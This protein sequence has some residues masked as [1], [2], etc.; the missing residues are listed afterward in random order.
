MRRKIVVVLI[1]FASVKV[2]FSQSGVVDFIK[3]GK[4]DAN[5][6]M[7]KYLDPFALSL[8]D[9][10][11]NAW[12]Y[13]AETHK[14]LGF[15]LSIST[16]AVMIPSSAKTFDLRSLSFSDVVVDGEYGYIAQ[17]VAGADVEGGRLSLLDP[18]NPSDTIGSFR[19]PPGVDMD[20]VPVPMVQ[21]AVG[22]APHTDLL[23]RYVPE[24]S[25]SQDGNDVEKIKVGFYGIGIKHEFKEW[26][27]F[28]KE[29]PFDAAVFTS[30]SKMD[31]NTGVDFQ[32]EDYG[33]SSEEAGYTPDKNQRLVI[34][35]TTLKYGLIISKKLSF[36][37]FYG[38]IG[39]SNSHTSADLLGKFPVVKKDNENGIVV[40]PEIDPI[41]LKFSSSRLSMDAGVRFKMAFFN[42]FGSINKAEYMSYNAGISFSFRE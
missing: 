14:I 10:L 17:T 31:A 16:S 18:D 19:T 3:A 33:Y 27:P 29:L 9:G 38:S 30:F 5:I 15:G 37:T 26:M 34:E 41:K 12:Y 23:L 28:L 39:N 11:N 2:G 36:I 35:T 32:L 7:E 21:L 24:L 6:L 1:L 13:T 8:G 20:V 4:T 42:I 25:F 22:V 40:E